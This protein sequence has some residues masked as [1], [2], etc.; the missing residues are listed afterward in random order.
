MNTLFMLL[1]LFSSLIMVLLIL[2]QRGKGG[3]L[4]GAFGGAGGQ[5]AFGTK[6]GDLFTKVT[7]VVAFVWI[8]LCVLAV[9]FLKTSSRFDGAGALPAPAAQKT[10]EQADSATTP[11]EKP[12][13]KPESPAKKAETSK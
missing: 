8:L 1:L 7:I 5:S 6:A 2:V 9:G 3:G 10:A 11:V 13:A 12:A 4:S